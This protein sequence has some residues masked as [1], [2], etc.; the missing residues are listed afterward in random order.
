MPVSSIASVEE[1][2]GPNQIGRENGRRRI[3]VY[4]NTD[5]GD[6][7]RVIADIRR[8]IAGT[9]LPSEKELAQQFQVSRTVVREAISK[10]QAAGMVETRHGVG[11]FVVGA[12]DVSSFRIEPQQ[13]ATLR[14]VVDEA[15]VRAK[16]EWNPCRGK[17]RLTPVF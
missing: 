15:I 12:G 13:L 17:K 1:S 11:T 8:I 10:L 9:A 3:I 6:M 5:G 2:D 7:G 14:D 4:A 16:V